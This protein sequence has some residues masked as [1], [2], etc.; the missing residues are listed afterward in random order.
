VIGGILASTAL[1]LLILSA[2]Y[3]WAHGLS[4]QDKSAGFA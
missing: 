3:M 1:T 2:Q 4:R